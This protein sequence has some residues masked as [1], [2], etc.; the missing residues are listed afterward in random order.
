MKCNN[1]R[2]IFIV[3]ETRSYGIDLA[4]LI[5]DFT[6]IL[7]KWA[8]GRRFSSKVNSANRESGFPTARCGPV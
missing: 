3:V 4:T 7:R 5:Y 2:A 6:V 8:V 1:L